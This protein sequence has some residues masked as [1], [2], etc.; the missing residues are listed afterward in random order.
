MFK[1][2]K[3]QVKAVY[4]VGI[5]ILFSVVFASGLAMGFGNVKCSA[6]M[7]GIL[8]DKTAEIQIDSFYIKIFFFVFGFMLPLFIMNVWYLYIVKYLKSL[9]L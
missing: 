4:W 9:E 2:T 1:I 7:P 5:V 3:T 6:Y 8:I